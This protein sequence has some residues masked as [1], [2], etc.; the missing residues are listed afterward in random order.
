MISIFLSINNNEEVFELPV[1]PEELEKQSPWQ[2]EEF[3]TMRQQLNLIGLKGLESLEISSF[4]PI[5]DYPFLRSREMWGMEY[6]E[7]IERW[8][9]RRL[10]LRLVITN[11]N[12]HGFKL[13]EAVTIDEFNYRTGKNGDI[14]YTMSLK[15]FPFVKVN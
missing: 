6:V 15:W 8:R 2:N 5:R 11:D 14:Y 13:N 9:N 1:V 3:E 4:F 10:P 7:T 12:P